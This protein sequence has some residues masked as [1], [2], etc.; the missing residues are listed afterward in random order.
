MSGWFGRRA[1][2]PA[3]SP[4]AA[5]QPASGQ[6][7][8]LELIRYDQATGKFELGQEALAVLKR[9]RGPV[10]VVAVCGRARQVRRRRPP[11]SRRRRPL[12]T[13]RAPAGARRRVAG[14]CAHS[15]CQFASSAR[16][17]NRSS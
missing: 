1:T 10:G 9:T 13:Q 15:V 17:A 5:A 7:V 8:P 12:G 11:S 3:A 4:A 6:G 14:P 16:R 2:P